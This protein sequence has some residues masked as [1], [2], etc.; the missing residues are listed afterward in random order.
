MGDMARKMQLA[1]AIAALVV[2]ALTPGA[3]A[4]QSKAPQVVPSVQV[5]TRRNGILTPA[6]VR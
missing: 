3:G 1:V 6:T 4:A 2:G 5:T